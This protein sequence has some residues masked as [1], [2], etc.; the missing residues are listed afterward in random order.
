MGGDH[1]RQTSL[2]HLF[3]KERLN[4]LTHHRIQTVKSL[5][6]QYIFR[7]CTDSQQQCQLFLHSFG[8][9]PYLPV[10]VQIKILQIFIE[11][12]SVEVLVNSTVVS[13]HRFRIGIGK[14]IGVVCNKKKFLLSIHIIVYR[15]VI[16]C[17]RPAV[18]LQ[19]AGYHAQH[20]TL[21]CPVGSYQAKHGIV[22]YSYADLVNRFDL[23]K[24][25]SQAMY[26]YHVFLP[27]CL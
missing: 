18:R 15:Y 14:K 22:L 5:I 8:K 27:F 21:A 7:M 12:G 19:H 6:T 3:G 16:H 23:V 25:L 13:L 24:G 9:T 1:R 11:L 4:A 20:R 2:L 17:Y 10:L 26:L